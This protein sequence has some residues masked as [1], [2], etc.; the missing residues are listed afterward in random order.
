[1]ALSPESKPAL[2]MHQLREIASRISA[3]QART[4]L[5]DEFGVTLPILDD[6]LAS[7]RVGATKTK[8][9]IKLDSSLD[10]ADTARRYARVTR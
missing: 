8:S 2:T 9:R 3:G 5:A 6:A 1:M 4:K 10:P 7:I